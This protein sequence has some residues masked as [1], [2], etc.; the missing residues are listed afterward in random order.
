[1]TSVQ[2]I[3]SIQ[4]VITDLEKNP[5]EGCSAGP[6]LDNITLWDITLFGPEGTPYTGGL[7]KIKMIFTNEYPFKPPKIIFETKILHCN[8]NEKG[9]ICIDLLKES[10]WNPTKKISEVLGSI[11]ILLKHPNPSEPL[12][13]EIAELY[14]NKRAIHDTTVRECVEKYAS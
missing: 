13:P 7:F 4:K 12:N 8:I 1:M 6:T 10:N 11:V 5:I 9:E 14:L 2:L 3:R